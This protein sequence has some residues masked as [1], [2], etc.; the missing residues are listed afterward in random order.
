MQAIEFKPTTPCRPFTTHTHPW[1]IVSHPANPDDHVQSRTRSRRDIKQFT[2]TLAHMTPKWIGC[3]DHWTQ[4]NVF[5]NKSYLPTARQSQL[6]IVSNSSIWAF[7]VHS[8]PSRCPLEIGVVYS[9]VKVLD[10]RRWDSDRRI[11][12]LEHLI[13]QAREWGWGSLTGSIIMDNDL[14][15]LHL[16]ILESIH[17]DAD[18][19][20]H[21]LWRL[22]RKQYKSFPA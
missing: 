10:K 16:H 20:L 8:Y 9:C 22:K 21:S 4:W 12:V 17:Y 18:K 14:D 11:K 5:R 3:S 19:R 1:A 2:H 15:A 7:I 13:L 6:L